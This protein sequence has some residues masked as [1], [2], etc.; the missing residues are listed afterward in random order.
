M[1]FLAELKRRNVF[2]VAVA[3][4][5]LTWLLVAIANLLFP[6]LGFS[7]ARVRWLLGAMLLAW[8]VLLLLAWRFELTSSGL[9]VDRG[10]GRDN[11][12]NARTGRRIDA[13]TVVLVLG[14][15]SLSI[16]H[17]VLAP[18]AEKRAL[19]SAP[20][21]PVRATENVPAPTARAGPVDPH[22]I[23]VLPFINRSP[24]PNDAFFADGLAEELLNVLAGI[25]G[26]KVTSRSSSFA[27]RDKATAG[28]SEIAARLGVAYLLEGSV[29]RQ[30]DEVRI[31]AQL[32]DAAQDQQLWSENY[33][34][35]LSD[36]FE[37]QEQISQSI[38]NALADSLGV[39][40]VKV[41]PATADL[42]AYEL[43]LRGRQLF[44]QRGANLPAARELL[45]RAVAL[46]A[47]FADAWAALAGT[48]YVWR[49]YSPEPAGVDTLNRSGEAA[50]RALSLNP[51]H[52]GALAVRARLDAANG[53]RLREVA[54]IA[55]ALELDPNNANTWLWQGLGRF[56]VGHFEAAHVSFVEAQ[57]LDP[58]SG[59]NLG[60]LGVTTALR[61]DRAAGEALLRQAHA[62]GWR[63][64]ASRFLYLLARGADP[65]GRASHEVQQ[66]YLDW[67]HDDDAM[68]K[69]QRELARSLAP[70]IADP[71]QQE[72]AAQTL[73]AAATESPALEWT[74]LLSAVGS[75]DAAL[76]AALRTDRARTQVLLLSLWYPNFQRLRVETRFIE[77][78]RRQGMVDYWHQKGP[79]DGCRLVEAPEARL[80]CA[81]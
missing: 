20:T 52:P 51:E 16:L 37:V 58:L 1:S 11:P 57:R 43:Y 32:I 10:P 64:P 28:S 15:L 63:G 30:G 68:P 34:R 76:E 21:S 46:D 81:K 38:A 39:R 19:L 17:Q 7:I 56:E 29:R 65:D 60:W 36:I 13:A 14:A 44:A 23:A 69:A 75:T 6:A 67:L 27:F 41:A 66:R 53:E 2:R 25:P 55:K 73:L 72:R 59:L 42:E 48:W 24:D 5:A 50:A 31:S 8:P 40:T 33:D 74:T 62:L 80:E 12:Q 9:R 71:E 35:R 79:P 61:G 3:W 18:Y 45:E 70:S 49:N 26:L 54:L 22:S 47:R 77:F 4:L 78:A